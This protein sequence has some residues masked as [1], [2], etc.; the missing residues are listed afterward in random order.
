MN[1]KLIYTIAIF[2]L[3]C[4]MFVYA[5]FAF[6]QWNINP[7]YWGSGNRG[8]ACFIV[9]LLTITILLITSVI[10]DKD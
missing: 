9:L 4:I 1:K 10:Y 7:Y 3:M 6:T 8:T 5:A 2:S